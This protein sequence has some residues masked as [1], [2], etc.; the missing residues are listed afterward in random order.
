MRRK[1]TSFDLGFGL[2]GKQAQF[3]IGV[4]GEKRLNGILLINNHI[5]IATALIFIVVDLFIMTF[6]IASLMP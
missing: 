1:I 5:H 6:A 4:I 3:V 2:S